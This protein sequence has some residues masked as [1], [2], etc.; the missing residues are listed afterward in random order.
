[1][2]P[3]KVLIVEDKAIVSENIKSVL[4]KAGYGIYGRVSSG[5]EALILLGQEIPDVILMDIKL[6]GVLD[7]IETA[8]RI[9]L[10]WQIPIVYLTD[11]SDKNTLSR[12]KH[13]KPAAYLLKPFKSRDLLNAIEIAFY[14]ASEKKEASPE[15][16]EKSPDTVFAFDDRFFIKENDVLFRVN[17]DEV[18][19]IEAD[20]AYCKIRTIKKN[21][22]QAYSLKIFNE[23]F[24][25]P[26]LVRVQRSYIVNIDKVTAIKGNML[27]I[28]E[29]GNAEI[30]VS[31][32]YRINI[33]GKFPVV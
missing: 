20:R 33:E 30:P 17:L 32:Q 7:G 21:Y 24:S 28:G 22:V 2:K 14:N 15:S 8:E 25:H 13:T 5:E 26:L 10:K 23:K 9:K 1:M 19:W 16:V 3:V 4:E 6:K 29:A 12:A 31:S 11:L 27:V 18:L